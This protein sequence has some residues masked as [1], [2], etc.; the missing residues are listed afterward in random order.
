MQYITACLICIWHVPGLFPYH[1][2]PSAAVQLKINY[3]CFFFCSQGCPAPSRT[4]KDS[5]ARKKQRMTTE[6]PL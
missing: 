6:V 5:K 4:L 1:I 2:K 3:F